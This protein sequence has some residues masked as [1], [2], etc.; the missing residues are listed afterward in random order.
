MKYPV[1]IQSFSNLIEN[2]Y[3][4]VDK[5]QFIHEMI[6]TG[7]YYFLSRPRRFGKSLLM[8]TIEALFQGKRQLFEGLAISHTDWLWREHEVI[9]IDFNGDNYQDKGTVN[10]VINGLLS[11][12]ENKYGI[13][14][15]AETFGL[16]FKDIIQAAYY[17]NGNG[18]VV[19]IDEYDKPILDVLDDEV[20]RDSNKNTLQAFYSVL[21]SMDRYVRFAMLT[22]ISKFSKVSIFSG[23]NNL[24][25]ISLSSKYNEICGISESE[26]SK[27]F[28]TGISNMAESMKISVDE[29]HSLLKKNYDG[30]HFSENGKDVY[31]PFSLLNTFAN[32][33]I[34]RYWF[35][36]G[37]PTS[38]IRLIERSNFSIP[39][40]EHYECTEDLLTGSDIYLKD[41]IPLLFQ[42]G[43]LTIKGFDKRFRLYTLGFPNTEVSEGFSRLLLSSF[44][45]GMNEAAIIKKFVEDVE[46][47]EAEA[48]MDKLQ[49]FFAGI[50]YDHTNGG[51]KKKE[52]NNGPI[53]GYLE[54]HYQNIMFVIMKLM[55]F[56]THTE[57][58]TSNGRIDMTIET[59]RYVYVMEFKINSSAEAAMKQIDN[60]EYSKPFK[61]QSK[62]LIKIGANFDTKTRTL[63]DF[64]VSK[65]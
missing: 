55:G 19:L 35:A 58:R 47:G 30:Y 39:E 34:S 27:Y 10:A 48:F 45:G 36:T 15:H 50:P 26:M 38:L 12:F 23:L 22:G 8:S 49:S 53:K 65:S 28:T 29:V 25:D 54:I 2:G 57:Y 11:K 43:Y 6:T 59:S 56:Y 14:D 37:T 42:A 1:G 63:S 21:K 18:V 31:N 9:H 60:K 41:P 32:E 3:L 46:K 5:T 7:K 20:V 4:Y 64:I 44:A 61:Y 40:L 62:E 24:N 16:R 33:T 13:T 17:K 51:K 52:D